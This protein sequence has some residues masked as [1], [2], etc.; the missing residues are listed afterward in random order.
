MES[1]KSKLNNLKTIFNNVVIL[2]CSLVCTYYGGDAL[3][4]SPLMTSC[5]LVSFLLRLD[6]ASWEAWS[7]QLGGSC[8][9]SRRRGSI[10]SMCGEG[11]VGEAQGPS[12]T[13]TGPSLLGKGNYINEINKGLV[14]LLE[15][16]G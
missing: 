3:F 1:G 10:S 7:L 8:S 11:L 16:L 6:S 13:K 5:L 14:I 12:A 4:P 2:V 15:M 9:N